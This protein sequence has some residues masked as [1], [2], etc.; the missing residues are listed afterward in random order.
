MCSENFYG[1]VIVPV[2]GVQGRD[3]KADIKIST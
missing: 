1:L 2:E 3:A